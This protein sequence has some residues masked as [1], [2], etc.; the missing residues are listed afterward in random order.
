MP[1]AHVLLE[2]FAGLVHA[3][4]DRGWGVEKSPFG[5]HVDDGVLVVERAGQDLAEQVDHKGEDMLV[6]TDKYQLILEQQSTKSIIECVLVKKVQNRIDPAPQPGIRQPMPIR[7][8]LQHIRPQRKLIIHS[9]HNHR[10]VN[11]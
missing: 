11:L 7:R 6:I 2:P 5:D 8:Y 10:I 4:D 1:V 9:R 3:E